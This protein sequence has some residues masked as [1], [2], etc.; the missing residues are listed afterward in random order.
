[1]R[2][3]K[4][5]AERKRDTPQFPSELLVKIKKQTEAILEANKSKGD[6]LVNR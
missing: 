6:S 2:A 3:L 1:M 5:Q 4:E